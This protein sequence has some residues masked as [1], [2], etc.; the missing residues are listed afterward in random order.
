MKL[1]DAL[2]KPA[3]IT[4]DRSTL[5]D[6][7]TCPLLAHLR[8]TQPV[9]DADL[10]RLARL[11]NAFHDVMKQYVT[12]IV[13]GNLRGG[14][15]HLKA[16][17]LA[18]DARYQ[19]ELLH[20]AAL[21]GAKIH[22]WPQS[23]ISHEKQYSYKLDRYG[24][25]SED[26]ILTCRPDLLAWDGSVKAIDCIDWK[27]GWG[28]GHDFQAM[29]YAVVIWKSIKGVERVT[30]RPFRARKGTWGKPTV[31]G[32][33][34]SL[35]ETSLPEAEAIVK[36]AAMEYMQCLAMDR[37]TPDPGSERCQWCD[38][39]S[40]CP[41]EVGPNPDIRQD[42]EKFLAHYMKDQE[43][44]K[45]HAKLLTAYVKANGPIQHDGYTWGHWLLSQKP[46][47]GL[48]KGEPCWAGQQ[49]NP[50]AKPLDTKDASDD[51]K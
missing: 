50:D 32:L 36:S 34:D 44:R 43:L 26:V 9:E 40:E 38:H 14:V 20:C 25:H 13:E 31:F 28:E 46:V 19:P 27:S 2:A 51:A 4:I 5:E 49:E 45:K 17:A 23:Y 6:F 7:L 24:P 48:R 33:G 3:A 39:L 42:P 12:E 37:W 41:V 21:T 11:G 1:I 29:F 8:K 15:D 16:I 30:W 10:K 47:F 22:I 18:G 35:L